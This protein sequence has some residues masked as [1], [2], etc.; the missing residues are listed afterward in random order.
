[1]QQISQQL[2]QAVSSGNLQT[3]LTSAGLGSVLAL[4]STVVLVNETGEFQ[5]DQSQ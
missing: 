2:D 1:M 4:T 3:V 5:I